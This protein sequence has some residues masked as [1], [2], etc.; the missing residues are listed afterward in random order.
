MCRVEPQSAECG[1]TVAR[2][3]VN[4]RI[5][6][7]ALYVPLVLAAIVSGKASVVFSPGH[8]SLW[9]RL[10]H[11]SSVG[12]VLWTS[13]SPVV[14]GIGACLCHGSFYEYQGMLRKPDGCCV[15]IKM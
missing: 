1:T 9:E 7:T 13:R 3:L 11:D 12:G 5:R 4:G 8:D 6:V 15:I 14:A 2:F 10:L